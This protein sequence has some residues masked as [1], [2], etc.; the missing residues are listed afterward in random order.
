MNSLSIIIPVLNEEIN[1]GQTLTKVKTGT[2]IEIIVV[3]EGSVDN[4]RA[5]A[6]SH[7]VKVIQSPIKGRAQQMNAGASI[8]QG[9]ILLFLHGDTQLPPNYDDYIRKAMVNPDIVAGAFSLRVT[10]E[11]RNLR[12]V[13]KLVYWRSRY[14]SLP[15][16][17]QGIFLKTSTLQT[18]G[19]FPDL[20]IMEDFELIL[21]LKKLGKILILPQAI[22][23]SGRRWQKLGILR[24]TII[25]QLV[26]LGYFL[27]INPEKLA[28]YYRKNR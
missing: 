23:T 25:N 5:I 27:G 1:I 14:L 26:I 13:E 19:G 2:N 6:E 12:I 18:L 15:Y 10:G 20:P 24:T 4:T 17:D 7:G 9:E 3:D 21:R 28:Q 22:N 16:G 8:A 11:D